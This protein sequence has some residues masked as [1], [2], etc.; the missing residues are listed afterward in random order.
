MSGNPGKPCRK[1]AVDQRGVKKFV[2][3]EFSEHCKEQF[4]QG[5]VICDANMGRKTAKIR[6]VHAFGHKIIS[7]IC[8]REWTDGE[9]DGTVILC[10]VKVKTS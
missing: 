6:K 3:V 8:R 10:K 5:W 1:Q 4:H 9:G 2:A 7:E